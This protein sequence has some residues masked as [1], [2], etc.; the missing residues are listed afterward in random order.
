MRKRLSA[1]AI[2]H[3]A[4]RQT[5]GRTH[6]RTPKVTLQFTLECGR[7]ARVD[8]RS[9]QIVMEFAH[10]KSMH[11][12]DTKSAVPPFLFELYVYSN[13]IVLFPRQSSFGIPSPAVSN[14]PASLP[15]SISLSVSRRSTMAAARADLSVGRS[16]VRTCAISRHIS[17]SQPATA[18]FSFS[19]STFQGSHEGTRGR[20]ARDET[21]ANT[22]V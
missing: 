11:W 12:L 4:V 10:R 20:I 19:R 21:E 7:T 8:R 15:P 2:A 1:S 9:L 6:A 17:N 22:V 5:D 18:V 3:S 16:V 14:T 13:S